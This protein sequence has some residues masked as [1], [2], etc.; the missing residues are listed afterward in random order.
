MKENS[1]RQDYCKY[2]FSFREYLLYLLEAAGAVGALAWIFYR[3]F[4]A[5]IVLSPIGYLLFC[6]IRKRKGEALRRA[7][8]EQFREC[9]LS[10]SASLQAGY[11]VENAF[12]ESRE[13]MRSL[14]GA[15]SHIY[16]ELEGIRR[17]LVIRI[18]LEELL[19]DFGERSGCNEISQFAQ[20]F[21]IAKQRGGNLSE[22]IHTSANLISR[23]MEAEKEI[24][25][26]LAGRKMEQ[27]IMRLMPFGIL[28]YVGSTYSGYLDA[29]Y[30][31]PSGVLV[32]SIC[33]VLYLAAY[34]AGE[35]IFD[36]IWSRLNGEEKQEKLPGLEKKGLLGKL[37]K[38]GEAGCLWAKKHGWE[39]G[40]SERIRYYLK[41]L[42]PSEN[43]EGL[44][45]QYYGGKI[46][47][48]V[49]VF[50]LGSFLVLCYEAVKNS[51]SIRPRDVGMALTSGLGLAGALF[52]LL[53]KDL[54]DQAER[55]RVR[56]RIGYPELV[57]RF[58]LYLAAGL[59]I[60]G[61]F[62]K[63]APENELIRCAC[64]E[65]S[66]GQSELTTYEHF[67]QMSGV[68]EYV[69]FSTLLCQNLK[70]GSNALIARL[71]EEALLAE[72]GRIQAGR[73][74][75]EEAETKLLIPMVMLLAIVMLMVMAPAFSMM[76]M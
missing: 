28:A 6:M 69:K 7:L 74:L 54:K 16:R 71:E 34:L 41:I 23:K 38:A 56:R 24:Q 12:L 14:Y 59:T 17:G 15:Q 32:M 42:R 43:R 37:V 31:E 62:Y 45:V 63:M 22:M 51:G 68:R 26:L 1:G 57:H 27:N 49:L 21:S 40:K 36:G 72:E 5:V 55:R 4:W 65:M 9:I 60:R 46:G 19:L 30:R 25:T 18:S 52:F 3:S 50:G 73:R 2:H 64:R 44:L 67:G 76:G 10:V 47:F 20:M 75:G 48:A 39:I 61:A 29:L 70:K 8:L 35:M 53:D 33:L 13:D 58:A 66:S 11:A